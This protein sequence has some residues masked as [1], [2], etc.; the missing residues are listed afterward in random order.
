M[1]LYGDYH[2]HSEFSRDAEGTI[3][4]IALSA[5]ESGLQEI[6][7]TDHGC[8][9]WSGVKPKHYPHIKVLCDKA[10]AEHGISVLF[11]VEANV[12]GSRGQVD[13]NEE[14]RRDFDIF[15]LGF[16]T[17]VWWIGFRPFFTI[18]LPNLF[19]RLF[20]LWPKSRIRKNTEIMKRAIEKNNVD[21][22]VHPNRY[23]KLDVV[24]VARTCAE[25]GT[26]VELNAKGVNYRPVDFERMVAVGAKFIVSSDAHKPCCVGQVDRV[27]EFLKNCDYPE[28]VIVNL[29]SPFSRPKAGLIEK[30]LIDEP[31]QYMQ[32]KEDRQEVK[33]QRK[34]LKIIKR[35]AID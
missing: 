24:E 5:K 15:L 35:K 21:I 13:I 20:R 4:E 33:K 1:K 19:C 28:E 7:I 34:F 29:H 3:D 25:M 32:V 26:L 18:F 11:G 8:K 17:G 23:F 12:T 27:E 14:Y 31:E 2:I 6:A 10:R 22:W 16:H 30:A 9:T